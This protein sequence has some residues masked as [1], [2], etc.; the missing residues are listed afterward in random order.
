MEVLVR[1]VG[2]KTDRPLLRQGDPRA[3][4]QALA[5]EREPVYALADITVDS[6]ESPHQ[7]TVN[8]IIE[9]LRAHIRS[10]ASAS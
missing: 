1:R 7:V 8:A 6:A 10:R 4:L 9:A 3:V 2:R 5:A